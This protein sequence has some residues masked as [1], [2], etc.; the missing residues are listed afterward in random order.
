MRWAW[1]PMV[2]LISRTE[3]LACWQPILAEAVSITNQIQEN[4]GVTALN[5]D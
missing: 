1:N 4:T 3:V 5:M 2:C